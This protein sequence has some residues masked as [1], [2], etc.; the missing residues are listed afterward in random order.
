MDTTLQL[1]RC[2][3]FALVRHGL[4]IAETSGL[5]KSGP[6]Q[7]EW[8]PTGSI[9][10]GGIAGRYFPAALAPPPVTSA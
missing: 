6:A 5:R 10:L 8:P 4:N 3:G 7:G 9:A 2:D 1:T